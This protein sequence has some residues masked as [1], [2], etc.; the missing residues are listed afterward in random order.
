MQT[1]TIIFNEYIWKQHR[2]YLSFS[3]EID[4][5]LGT[6]WSRRLERNSSKCKVNYTLYGYNDDGEREAERIHFVEKCNGL[7]ALKYWKF[8]FTIIKNDFTYK[9]VQQA[10]STLHSRYLSGFKL[11][12]YTYIQRKLIIWRDC[13]KAIKRLCVKN[14][15]EPANNLFIN[16]LKWFLKF[17]NKNIVG[18]NRSSFL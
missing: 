5:V 14:V 15:F 3:D 6:P 11:S 17:G 12:E 1:I 9:G 4:R 13:K 10:W 16:E 18:K 7:Y 8:M 2:F